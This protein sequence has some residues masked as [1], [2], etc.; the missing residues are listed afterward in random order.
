MKHIDTRQLQNEYTVEPVYVVALDCAFFVSEFE[1][2]VT[3]SARRLHRRI[4]VSRIAFI[5]A[6]NGELNV[7][8]LKDSIAECVRALL[9]FNSGLAFDCCGAQ[10]WVSKFDAAFMRVV[11]HIE[12]RR[13]CYMLIEKLINNI[14]EKLIRHLR[15]SI[16]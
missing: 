11:C 5:W 1:N 10:F 6:I 2:I 14:N 9:T 16:V 15:A 4:H 3:Y 12:R 7:E 13:K 8:M